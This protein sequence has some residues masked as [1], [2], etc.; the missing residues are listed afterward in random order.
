[1]TPSL[2]GL[3]TG[4]VGNQ[5]YNL[6]VGGTGGPSGSEGGFNLNSDSG[7]FSN[8]GTNAQIVAGQVTHSN[9][10]SRSWTVDW[11]A[12]SNGTGNVTFTLAVN[13]VNGNGA[14]TGDGWGTLSTILPEDSDG[15]GWTNLEE[16]ACGS[17]SQD[18]TD[19]PGDEDGD[20]TCDGMDPDFTN[21]SNGTIGFD[22]E[23]AA[24][25]SEL[26]EEVRN[27]TVVSYNS[28]WDALRE[29]DEDP[30]NPSNVSLIYTMRSH[31]ENDTCGDGNSCTGQSWNREH[32]WPQSHG[33]FGTT[34]SNVAGTD[35][36]ALRPA[37]NT[38]NSARSD[39]DFDNATTQHSECT[40]CN[41]STD[42]WEPPAEVKGDI[43]RS[44]FYMDVRYNGY[45][46]EPNLTLMD[47]Y[48]SPS[49]GNGTL[50]VVCALYYWHI[51]DPVDY[52]EQDRND[53]VESYQDNRNPFVDNPGFV[54]AIWGDS[55][56]DSEALDC[57]PG[58]YFSYALGSCQAADPGFY[59]IGNS[60]SQTPCPQGT[61]QNQT[62]QASCIDASPGYY[63]PSNGSTFQTA[64]L[65]GTY[66]PS[67][68]QTSCI[69]ASVGHFVL[70]YNSTSQTPCTPGT[71]QP[72]TG[73]SFCINA[74][75]G[76]Y[77]NTSASTSQ[78]ECDNGTWQNQTGQSSCLNAD[79]GHYV[80]HNTSSEQYE[81]GLGT[82]QPY[83]GQTSC[84]EADI[85]YFVPDIAS[86]NQTYCGWNMT[87]LTSGSSSCVDDTDGD[88]T[89][90]IL[91]S[92]D[93]DDGWSDNDENN[94]DS[95]AEDPLSVPSDNDGDGVCN[96]IDTDDDNDGVLDIDDAFP[97][98]SSE[99]T[100]MDGDGIGDNTDEDD[101]GDGWSDYDEHHCDSDPMDSLSVPSDNDGDGVCDITDT[102]D[103]NDGRTDDIDAFPIDP[104]EWQDTDGDG[105]G[106][107]ADED[108]DGDGWLDATEVACFYAGG[109]GDPNNV[110]VM[111]IDYDGDDLCDA[112]DTDDDND[113]W[114]DADEESCLTDSQSP[115]SIPSDTDGNG[116]CDYLDSPVP[117]DKGGLPG[118]G[119]VA[120]LSALA[121]AAVARRD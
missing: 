86:T 57:D 94:C 113:G 8:A 105:L 55:C 72:N 7:S 29:T 78:I 91:D 97:M 35:L 81:C 2:G 46:S 25:H 1:M 59:A 88:G 69:D 23:A 36:H 14:N 77:V 50:G 27:H 99:T 90:N 80:D 109:I 33:D 26:Y 22:E 120:V 15:D 85:G 11:T 101:D 19:T 76:Y 73:Q 107:N 110:A 44:I 98:D 65:P 71:Y 37:D 16:D 28:A 17:D 119:L 89:A 82:Y 75:P 116:I 61:W 43:A 42:A 62:G 103:D 121:L 74:S 39:K 49:S 21:S 106:N 18:G 47:E 100:D 79:P 84:L 52:K 114:S 95:D 48:T 104:N 30:A 108:D 117:S 54:Q 102:D 70:Y 9:S 64:C 68:G 5:T 24:L 93:D 41:Y 13:F 51:G 3:D 6:T 58:H 12:P 31:S 115:S 10:N 45:G 87:T 111:P 4:Y 56:G 40:G 53:A 34:M 32:L 20:G 112:V 38:V 60:T 92:D 66:Q 67:S 96:I 83:S 118:F 63:S